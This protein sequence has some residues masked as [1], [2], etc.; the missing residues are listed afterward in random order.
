MVKKLSDLCL[1]CVGTNLD[2]ISRVGNFLPT[3]YK[4]LLLERLACHDRLTPDYLR[5]ISYHLFSPALTRICFYKCQQVTDDVLRN[6]EK[7]SCKLQSI[8]VHGCNEISDV[9][10]KSL[11]SNQ[12]ELHT[13]ELRKLPHLTFQGLQHVSSP[14]LLHVDLRQ[15]AKLENDGVQILV[16]NNPT[17][18]TLLIPFCGK[19]CDEIVIHI[20]QTLLSNLEILD[21]GGLYDLGDGSVSVLAQKCHNLKKLVLHGCSR[22]TKEG[23]KQIGSNC[24]YLQNLDLAYC[25]KVSSTADCEGLLHLPSSLEDLSLCGIQVN[26][27]HLP[28][29]LCRLVHLQSVKLCGISTLSDENME[30]IFSSLGPQLDLV[31]LN[32]C[33]G[34]VTDSILR[35]MVN[36]CKNLQSLALSFCTKVSGETLYPLLED[37]KRAENITTLVLSACMSAL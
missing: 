32:C 1:E 2:T 36:H 15:C 23:L 37:R 27:Q 20:A 33:G 30:K 3:I 7:S 12:D 8:T 19:L 9:G 5:H 13:L 35:S 34:V 16:T 17:I 29:I 18:R 26:G 25:Y 6:I 14:V 28:D 31:D 21:I 10:I 4:E 11:V 22:V 24:K